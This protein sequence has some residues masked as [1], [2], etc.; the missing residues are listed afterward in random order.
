MLQFDVAKE[1]SNSFEPGV[2]NDSGREAVFCVMQN[3]ISSQVNPT[4]VCDLGA[5]GSQDD[6]PRSQLFLVDSFKT[7]IFNVLSGQQ[8]RRIFSSKPVVV[9]GQVGERRNA[10]L[11]SINVSQQAPAVSLAAEKGSSDIRCDRSRVSEPLD[12]FAASAVAA[13]DA[14][15][16]L[17]VIL[18]FFN[19]FK[20]KKDE[21]LE[22][23]AA[24]ER[25]EG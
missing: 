21:F 25:S 1:V 10:K 23:V 7:C 4:V 6:V 15:E 17:G 8:V 5:N 11:C 16:T 13:Q 20:F 24:A 9:S 2:Q 18:L 22:D 19:W 12:P 3:D 14:P